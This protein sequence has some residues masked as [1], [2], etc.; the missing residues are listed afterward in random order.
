MGRPAK[1]QT[2]E[3]LQAAIDAY[4][5]SLEEDKT[6][7]LSGLAYA[8]GFTSRQSLYDYAERGEDFSYPIKRIVLKIESIYESNLMNGKANTAGVIFWLKNRGWKDTHT[9]ED[10]TAKPRRIE[11]EFVEASE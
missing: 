1:Y 8:L 4:V 11:V 10:V 9:H 2:A 6:P 3:E 7:T 5:E